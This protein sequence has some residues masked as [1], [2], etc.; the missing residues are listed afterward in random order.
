ML[1]GVPAVAV[2]LLL[3]G[4]GGGISFAAENAVPGDVLYP[5][6]ISVNEAVMAKLAF[7]IEEQARL[8]AKHAMRRLSEAERLAADLRLDAESNAQLQ[9]AF[10]G[11][12]DRVRKNM[13]LL[14]ASQDTAVASDIGNDFEATL[15]AHAAVM[16]RLADSRQERRPIAAL[17][18]EVE[19]AKQET[20]RS[21]V[22]VEIAMSTIPTNERQASAE[23]SLA[24]AASRL[25][26]MRAALERKTNDDSEPHDKLA[27]A[28]SMLTE[29][30]G[31]IDEGS[32][33][34]GFGLVRRSMRN[35]EE[36][37]L[38]ND[39][40]TTLALVRPPVFAAKQT[41]LAE[42]PASNPEAMMIAAQPAPAGATLADDAKTESDAPTDI[43]EHARSRV[44][45]ARKLLNARREALSAEAI[46]EATLKLEGADN[47][48]TLAA[49]FSAKGQAQETDS[50][51]NAA[52]SAVDY[53]ETFI[54]DGADAGTAN[55]TA[56]ALPVAVGTQPMEPSVAAVQLESAKPIFSPRYKNVRKAIDDFEHMLRQ[57]TGLIDQEA[58]DKAS[59]LLLPART[60]LVEAQ[61]AFDAGNDTET[62]K[63]FDKALEFTKKGTAILAKAAQKAIIDSNAHPSAGRHSSSN[64]QSSQSSEGTVVT[65]LQVPGL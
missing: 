6:K 11:H 9:Q 54:G 65:P 55:T 27:L 18:K 40:G 7:S 1:K 38:L 43:V 34:D 12:A 22:T 50:Y 13:S 14:A 23:D 10:Q 20:E 35:A 42:T 19:H 21:R 45:D 49:D 8:E 36:A 63:L 16:Q 44:K 51:A 57:S 58:I 2:F 52:L 24:S 56:D 29:A 32:Y 25:V 31:K 53:V 62:E 48:L 39:F 17:L 59:A 47:T 30:R 26:S 33:A 64:T 46:N 3:I 28:D 41:S 5:V 61:A 37:R 4:V 15:E 60:T